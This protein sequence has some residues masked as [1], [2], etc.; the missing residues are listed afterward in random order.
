MTLFEKIQTYTIEEMAE[1]I[2]GLISGTEE[3]CLISL[4]EKGIDASFV[5]LAPEL[6][7]ADNVEMLMQEVD[8]DT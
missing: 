4:H 7:I 2:Y 6:C 1:F 5:S 3:K 8:D